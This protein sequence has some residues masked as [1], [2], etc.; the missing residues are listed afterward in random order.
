MPEA[1]FVSVYEALAAV[2]IRTP[3]RNTLYPLTPTLSELALHVTV[4]FVLSSA[5]AVTF[6]GT[7]GALVSVV[8]TEPPAVSTA[9]CALTNPQPYQLS[10]PDE[11]RSVAEENSALR[12]W[13]APKDGLDESI[14]PSTPATIGEA[15]EV[16]EADRT[17]PPL[18]V[19]RIDD[20]GA[21]IST[22][23]PKE[24]Q[25]VLAFALS[26]AETIIIEE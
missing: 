4:T 8:G 25:L 2:P 15:K 7:E 23:F 9:F 3:S 11:P 12:S 1:M 6:C 21:A 20:P 10:Q 24:D 13:S 22:S 17:P 5:R 16:P 19:V 26:V 18:A 14:R